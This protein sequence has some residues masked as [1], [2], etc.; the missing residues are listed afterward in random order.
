[1]RIEEIHLVLLSHSFRYRIRSK[2]N[3]KLRMA[4]NKW[5]IFSTST[6]FS[7][8]NLPKCTFTRKFNT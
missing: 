3:L 6:A 2:L 1:M 7:A 8:K 4:K 5:N